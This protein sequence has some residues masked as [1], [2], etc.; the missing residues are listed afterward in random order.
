MEQKTI[1]TDKARQGRRGTQVLTVLVVALVLAAIAW[2]AAE[3]YGK[4]TDPAVPTNS[5]P[6]NS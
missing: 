1:S 4:S 3:M 2:F 6:T 5:Q